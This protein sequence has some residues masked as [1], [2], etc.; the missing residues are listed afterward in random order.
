MQ[1]SKLSDDE[2]WRAI[3]HN[4]DTMSDLLLD[5][6]KRDESEINPCTRANLVVFLNSQYSDYTAEL[7]RRHHCPEKIQRET[8][9]QV[10]ARIRA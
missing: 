4:T 9:N 1:C 8:K 10:G 6:V 5:E 3:A 7:R 2:L